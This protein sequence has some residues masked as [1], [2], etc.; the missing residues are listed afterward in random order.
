MISPFS[1][2]HPTVVCAADLEFI[3]GITLRAIP[4][5]VVDDMA[6][7]FINEVVQPFGATW[8]ILTATGADD[9]LVTCLALWSLLS[10][11]FKAIRWIG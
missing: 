9:D 4:I 3:V 7:A 1:L 10:G 8:E 5:E 11:H 2:N 6:C